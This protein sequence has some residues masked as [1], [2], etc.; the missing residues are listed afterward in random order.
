MEFKARLTNPY[1]EKER[2]N[3]IVVN[4]HTNGYIIKETEEG[5]EAWGYTQEEIK[6]KEKEVTKGMILLNQEL[7][8]AL[9]LKG[10]TVEEITDNKLYHYCDY[11]RDHIFIS[12]L[13]KY[14]NYKQD[15]IDYL[16]K[17]KVFPY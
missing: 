11:S 16:F 5:L 2:V 1:T 6:Q 12:I 4:N 10:K 17:Y 8:C 9:A 14:F 3:F 15:D 7:K 13:Q